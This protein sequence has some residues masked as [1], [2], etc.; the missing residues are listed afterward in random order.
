MTNFDPISHIIQAKQLHMDIASYV[1]I[2]YVRFHKV[3]SF[4][5]LKQ[6]HIVLILI[7]LNTTSYFKLVTLI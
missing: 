5:L 1:F 6:T 2:T 4:F 3:I 7:K